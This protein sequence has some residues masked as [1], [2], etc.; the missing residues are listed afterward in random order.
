[1]PWG[2]LVA[3][4]SRGVSLRDLLEAF[5]Q[6]GEDLWRSGMVTSHGGNLSVRREGEMV[7]TRRGALLG[8]LTQ[9][10]L[11]RVPLEGRISER[12]SRETPLHRAVY[13]STSAG[14]VVHS[15]PVHAIALS[16]Y[17]DTI[18]PKD[19]EGAYI[20]PSVPVVEVSQPIG[21][22]ELAQAVAQ[23]LRD[24]PIVVVRG[25]GA[26]AKGCDLWDA[27]HYTSVLET[28]CRIL[29]LLLLNEANG[30]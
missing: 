1:M 12:A 29:Y 23:A 7:I 14:A 10:D 15:H 20:L 13:L 8:H 2:G 4:F 26:F 17:Q 22:Q 16:F 30:H 19:A 28:S 21:S 18:V 9:E 5:R 27:L 24:V 3:V 25:H 6:V 11:V